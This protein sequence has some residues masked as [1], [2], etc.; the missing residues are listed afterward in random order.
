MKKVVRRLW[1]LRNHGYSRAEAID[2]VLKEFHWLTRKAAT[3]EAQPVFWDPPRE[4][5][6]SQAGL[7]SPR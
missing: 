3:A 4:K 7:C 6:L 1:E 5:Q 2:T